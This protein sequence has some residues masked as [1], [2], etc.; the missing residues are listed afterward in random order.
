MKSSVRRLK[1]L[2]RRSFMISVNLNDGAAADDSSLWWCGSQP[3]CGAQFLGR[4]SVN[5]CCNFAHVVASVRRIE[6]DAD[7]KEGPM[8]AST[9]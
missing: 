1:V 3:V 9:G 5:L 4:H 8:Q 2:Y 6:S 7:Q